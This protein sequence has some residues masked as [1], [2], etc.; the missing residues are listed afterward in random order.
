MHRAQ[1][2]VA[3]TESRQRAIGRRGSSTRARS[4]RARA[5]AIVGL[6]VFAGACL[7]G[8]M[9]CVAAEGQ[10]SAALRAQLLAQR[11]AEIDLST[12]GPFA[13]DEMF[14]FDP[15]S[16]RDDN[17]KVLLADWFECRVTFPAV[18]ADDEYFLV[19]RRKLQII[20]AERHPRTNAEFGSSS[21]R[22]PQPVLRTAA[23]FRV[24]PASTST[25][26]PA[27]RLEFKR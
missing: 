15:R 17:C 14:I 13:W 23:L 7:L 27:F 24:E 3:M 5:R 22:H 26:T 25:S 9:T 11:P 12:V 21:G 16:V 6:L 4:D 18:V 2:N 1:S 8:S 19:F 10:F 20:R